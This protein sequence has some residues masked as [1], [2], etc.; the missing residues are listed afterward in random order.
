MGMRFLA[1]PG[2]GSQTQGFLIPWME[3]V[4]GFKTKLEELSQACGKDLVEL[5]TVSDEETIKDTSN[6]QPLIV[7]SAI[8]AY[9]T[10]LSGIHFDG[11]VGHSVGEFAAAAIAEVLTDSEAMRLVS[12][13]GNAMARASEKVA[14][15]MVAVLGGEEQEVLQAIADAGLSP[16]NYNGAGQIVAAGAK[17]GVASLLENPPAKARVIEL[18]VAG[19]FHSEFMLEAEQVLREAANSSVASDPKLRLLSNSSGEQIDSGSAFLE[20]MIRQVSRPVRWDLCMKSMEKLDAQLIELPPAG[21]LAG[22]AKRGMPNSQAIAL[23]TPAD[24]AKIEA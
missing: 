2:Q 14:T 8:A 19:G 7:G 3:E 24:L 12:I 10:A 16:A 22:L 1:C 5:G 6:S 18:K 13:R 17:S 4:P 11:V 21:A 20:L 23:K 15:S 9:R